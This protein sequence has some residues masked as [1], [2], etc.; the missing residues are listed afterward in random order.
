MAGSPWS[1]LLSPVKRLPCSS[2]QRFCGVAQAVA[3]DFEVGA[4]RVAAEHAAGVGVVQVLALLGLDVEPAVADR[5]IELAVG[6]EAQAVQVVAFEAVADAVT[7]GEDFA[8]VA[9]ARALGVSQEPRGWDVG[10]VDVALVHE[11]ARG[12]AIG[13]IVEPIG[14]DDRLIAPAAC[15]WCLPAGGCVGVFRQL[16]PGRA[17]AS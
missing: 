6:A 13:E 12:D 14:P 2:K 10:E 17:S 8:F 15:R 4:V 3:E 16:L 9:D 7:G 11:D 5:E 1:E